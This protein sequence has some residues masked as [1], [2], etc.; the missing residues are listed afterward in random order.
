[1]SGIRR[2]TYQTPT[3]QAI[4]TQKMRRHKQKTSEKARRDQLKRALFGLVQV[5][6]EPCCGNSGNSTVNARTEV[7]APTIHSKQHSQVEIVNFAVQYILCLQR[8]APS[9]PAR[10]ISRN[11]VYP[12]DR[13]KYWNYSRLLERRFNLTHPCRITGTWVWL[14]ISFLSKR[15]GRLG[16]SKLATIS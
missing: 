1:M 11:P 8:Q 2:S 7:C 3:T 4:E 13:A 10:A 6:L 16:L 14:T 5:M 9:W 12:A 15:M